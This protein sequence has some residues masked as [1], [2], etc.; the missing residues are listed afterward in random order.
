MLREARSQRLGRGDLP[1]PQATPM[2]VAYLLHLQH[3]VRVA[4]TLLEDVA[5]QGHI[6][7][8]GLLQPSAQPA[9]THSS[10]QC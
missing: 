2:A 8:G 9:R 4:G 3:P 5:T 7:P 10:A 1:Q 6:R